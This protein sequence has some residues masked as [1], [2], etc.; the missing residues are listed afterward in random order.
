MKKIA[1]MIAISAFLLIGGWAAT[2][3]NGQV[4]GTNTEGLKDRLAE[5]GL[6]A[7]TTEGNVV[8]T[9]QHLD[10]YI[11]GK[12]MEVPANIGVGPGESYIAPIHTHDTTG[13]IHIESPTNTKYY[14]GQFLKIWGIAWPDKCDTYINGNKANQD[15]SQIELTPYEE[16]TISCG[17]AAQIPKGYSFPAGY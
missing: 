14:L 6:P 12:K 10:V 3:G 13:I 2:R 4:L 16:I 1:G 17:Q 9:H 15:A 11:N 8:H 5:I 7:L